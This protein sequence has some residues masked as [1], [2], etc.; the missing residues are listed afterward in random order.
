MIKCKNCGELNPED[1]KICLVCSQSLEAAKASEQEFSWE[2]D[3]PELFTQQLR[4]HFFKMMK[5]RVEAELDPKGYRKYFDHFHA[6]GF[7]KKFDARITQLIA[8]IAEEY[9]DGN[10]LQLVKTDQSVNSTL[11]DLLDAFIVIYAEPLH[12]IKL[13]PA[14]LNYNNFQNGSPDLRKMI[15]DFLDFD[16]KKDKVFIDDQPFPER[17]LEN[18]KSSFLFC[19][20]DEKLFFFSDQTV[21][22]FCREGFAMTDQALYWKAHFNEAGKVFYTELDAIVRDSEWIT[23]NGRFFNV[24]MAMNYKMALLLKKIKKYFA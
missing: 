11:N 14:I 16:T 5:Q 17:K 15:F 24:N 10:A 21:F 22:G 13:P 8:E 3:Q 4:D 1:I 19:G 6:S 20:K 18:A 9:P 12:K 2:L 23:I 7:Y